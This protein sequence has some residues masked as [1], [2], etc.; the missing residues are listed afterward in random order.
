MVY[1]LILTATFWAYGGD[2]TAVHVEHDYASKEACHSA[3]EIARKQLY[4]GAHPA[5]DVQGTCLK[6]PALK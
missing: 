4:T 3:Y 6:V 5:A 1:T 2:A